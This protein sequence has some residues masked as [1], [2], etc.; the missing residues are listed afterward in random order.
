MKWA[1]PALVNGAVGKTPGA[2]SDVLNV[3]DVVFVA[4]QMNGSWRLMQIPEVQGAF[5]ALDP[6]DGG[7]AALVGGFDFYLSKFNR[8]VQAQRQPGSSFKPFLYSAA[9]EYGF[10]PSTLVNDAP[11]VLD[12]ASQETPFRAQHE[13]ARLWYVRAISSR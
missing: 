3:G 1:A 9:L 10:T 13:F 4:Q 7:V 12:D 6:R 8:A 2:A 11:I 5:V